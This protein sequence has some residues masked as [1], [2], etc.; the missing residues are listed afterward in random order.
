MS[1]TDHLTVKCVWTPLLRDGEMYLSERIGEG[2]TTIFG[3]FP[4]K[5]VQALIAERKA[6]IEARVTSHTREMLARIDDFPLDD[7]KLTA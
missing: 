3:P 5:S 6:E 2:F 7:L 1:A 4:A